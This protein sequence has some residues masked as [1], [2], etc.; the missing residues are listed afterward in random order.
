MF[1]CN[2]QRNGMHHQRKLVGVSDVT[3]ELKLTQKQE[4]EIE[5]SEMVGWQTAEKIIIKLRTMWRLHLP[6]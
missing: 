2:F 6:N 4:Q 5:T 1:E 3:I